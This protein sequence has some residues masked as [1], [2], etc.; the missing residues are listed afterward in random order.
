M[1]GIYTFGK[2]V[3][4]GCHLNCEGTDWKN[5]LLRRPEFVAEIK[6]LL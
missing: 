5:R 2:K 4:L 1:A 6:K 3:S